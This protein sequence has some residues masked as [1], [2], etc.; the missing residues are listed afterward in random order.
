VTAVRVAAARSARDLP[1][2]RLCAWTEEVREEQG[3][4]TGLEWFPWLAERLR[5]QGSARGGEPAYGA[6]ARWR[7]RG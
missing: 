6:F 4:D 1:A 2:R 7:P 5:E 3:H